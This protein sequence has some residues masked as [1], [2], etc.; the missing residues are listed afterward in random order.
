VE[1]NE[2]DSVSAVKEMRIIEETYGTN[3]ALTKSA[4]Q[5]VLRI[6]AIEDAAMAQVV[7]DHIAMGRLARILSDLEDKRAHQA[8]AVQQAK[9]GFGKAERS[10]AECTA[11]AAGIDED[12][13]TIEAERDQLLLR[14]HFG[15]RR[16]GSSYC[17]A[18][19]Q[20]ARQRLVS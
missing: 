11:I 13:T 19:S 20:L 5:E 7:P 14:S 9:D 15:S 12:I 16:F 6:Q 17:V 1:T 8:Q 18:C 4:Y 3:H 2:P 10:L